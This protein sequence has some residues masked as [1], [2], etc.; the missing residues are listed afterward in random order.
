MPVDSPLFFKARSLYSYLEFRDQAIL[1]SQL[2][3]AF[4]SQVGI[5]ELLCSPNIIYFLG[6]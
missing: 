6:I 2:A 4:P 3:V 5:G 1:T